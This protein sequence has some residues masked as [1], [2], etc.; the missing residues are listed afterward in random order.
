MWQIF[1]VRQV[2][3]VF[4]SAS[5]PYVLRPSLLTLIITIL[6]LCIFGAGEAL[7]IGAHFGVSPWTVLAQGLSVQCS[8]SVGVATFI[9]S[10]LV[11]LLW[12]PL[13]QKPGWGTF[14]NALVV[15]VMI[16][17]MTPIVSFAHESLSM[18]LLQVVLGVLLVGI[19]SGVYLVGNL[20]AGPRDG[21]MTGCQRVTN[22]PIALVRSFIELSAV[23]CGMA[24]GGIVGWGTLIFALGVGPTVSMGL[25]AMQRF[26]VKDMQ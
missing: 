15:A 14:L 8:I 6:G 17:W 2:P 3:R 16:E 1:T 25:Y 23:I 19:G 11:L 24:L 26:S 7:M 20:G 13:A 18:I 4:W 22:L 9:V 5:T 12:I 10:I 21:L